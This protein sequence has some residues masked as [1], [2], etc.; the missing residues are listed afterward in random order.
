[1][2]YGYGIWLLIDNGYLQ[3]HLNHLGH[4]TLICN[5][6]KDDMVELYSELLEKHIKEKNRDMNYTCIIDDKKGVIFKSNMY[7][8]TEKELAA[9]GYNCKVL[10]HKIIAECDYYEGD[11]PEEYHVTME[12]KIKEEELTIH[13]MFT[14]ESLKCHIVM[15]DI[16]DDDP[17]NWEIIDKMEIL[18]EYI[19]EYINDETTDN[20]KSDIIQIRKYLVEIYT[21][22]NPKCLG[23][24]DSMLDKYKGREHRLLQKVYKKY[25]G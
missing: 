10:E 12:Y 25:I 1:M 7:S 9:W 22:H 13:D 15:A 20:T 5:M 23:K 8:K 16:R 17:K 19:N 11:I 2:G 21:E 6:S 14:I 4:V 18:N 24:I 3:E